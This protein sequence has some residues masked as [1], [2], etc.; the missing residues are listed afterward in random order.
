M[1]DPRLDDGAGGGTTGEA[2]PNAP[3]WVKV[4][5][6]IAVVLL[7]FVAVALLT[8]HGPG[9]HTGSGNSGGHSAP[10]GA[11]DSGD[12]GG[13]TPPAGGHAP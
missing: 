11:T 3:R 12:G 13:H 1:A 8:G 6:V 7:A 4:S 10:A 9:R 5:A 2:A